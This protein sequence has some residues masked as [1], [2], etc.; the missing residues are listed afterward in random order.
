MKLKLSYNMVLIILAATADLILILNVIH[1][2]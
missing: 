1:H 2:W